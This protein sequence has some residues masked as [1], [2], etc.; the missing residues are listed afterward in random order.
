MPGVAG[1]V[2]PHAAP[3]R[4]RA[5][6]SSIA[7]PPGSVFGT[8]PHSAAPWTPL[9]PRI[10]IRPVRARPSMPRANA[11]LTSAATFSTP[12]RCCVTP[13]LQTKT[14][15]RARAYCSAKRAMS[16][17]DSPDSRSSSSHDWVAS[18]ASSAAKPVVCASMN[19]RSSA[20]RATS[21]FSTPLANARSPPIATWKKSSISALPKTA[22]R[23]TD[24]TQ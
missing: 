18:A 5:S 10:G 19:A 23:A 16:S 9:W 17:R 6:A 15:L 24:G 7:A 1:G 20:S 12:K 2:K 8:L 11:R 22:L 13:M 14:A 21:A 4:A 3:T